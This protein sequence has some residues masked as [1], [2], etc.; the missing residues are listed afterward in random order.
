MFFPLFLQGVIG[1]SATKSGNAMV[2]M[3]LAIVLT[4]IIGGR[5]INKVS[6]RTMFM[7][8]MSLMSVSLYLLSMMTIETTQFVATSYIVVLGLGM[9]LIMPTVT[10]A[11]QSAFPPEQRGVATS[12]T[13][14]FRSIGGTL[15]MTVLGVVF[16]NYSSRIMGQKF[17]PAI[18]SL[19]GLQ[20]GPFATMLEKAHTDPHSLFNILL[21]PE[22]LKMIPP[23]L[24][25]SI[26]P[27]LKNAL[28]D[29]LQMVFWV[30]MFITIAG[31]FISLLMGNAG[32][33]KK[34]HPSAMEEAGVTLFAEGMATEVELS[35]ELVPDLIDNA[36]LNKP[37][38][39]GLKKY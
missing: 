28:A 37:A 2:P 29:S 39:A 33:A 8:G 13:Q 20:T 22:A 18:Q 27:P 21:S 25:Q 38:N 9:G 1:L 35:A 17:F 31:I 3:M 26:L 5:F 32:V 11:V 4:S 34:T 23:N 30:A 19:P 7:A 24:Q 6:F 14:F 12:A 15:G 36:I 16:N 10:L